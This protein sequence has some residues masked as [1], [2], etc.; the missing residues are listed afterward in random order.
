MY[1]EVQKSSYH[2]TRNPPYKKPE[3]CI[4][5]H[6]QK[7]P[8]LYNL[9]RASL[10]AHAV[11]HLAVIQE[12]QV[13]SVGQEDPLE[14]EMATLSNILA[15]C[16]MDRGAW[17]VTVHGVTQSWTQLKAHAQKAI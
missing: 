6:V 9:T 7:C 11:K 8:L 1:K 12:T 2:L 14:K 5:M 3:T 16:P 17:Q 13:Q 4:K 15:W 10:M